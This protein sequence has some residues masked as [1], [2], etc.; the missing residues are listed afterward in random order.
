MAEDGKVGNK[1]MVLFF[2]KEQVNLVQT[3]V[4][5]FNC[6]FMRIRVRMVECRWYGYNE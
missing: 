6:V 1:V 4:G 5:I 3:G 2:S